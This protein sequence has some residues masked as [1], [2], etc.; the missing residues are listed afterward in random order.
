MLM[1]S[2]MAWK[3]MSRYK[4]RTVITAFAI[5]VG[6]AISIAVQA[7]LVGLD[8]DSF[9]NL[10]WYETASAKVYAPGYFKER[11]QYPIENLIPASERLSLERTLDAQGVL[12][13][14]RYQSMAEIFFLEDT[15]PTTGSL[16]GIVYGVDPIRDAEVYKIASSVDEG[17]WLAPGE[18]GVV[19]G[20]WLAY[21]MQAEVGYYVTIQCKG[22]GGFVQT[23]DVPVVGIVQTDNPVVNTTAMYMD[24]DYLDEMLEL[25]GDVSD[26]SL[27]L[28]SLSAL[29][30]AK[31]VGR[32][33]PRLQKNLSGLEV[34]GWEQ[35]AEDEVSMSRTKSTASNLLLIFLFIIAA[36]GISNTMLMAVME[37]KDEI[38][39]L[40]TL[41]YSRKHIEFL[42]V[43]EGVFIG[44]LGSVVGLVAGIGLTYPLV[45]HGLDF[46]SLF[47]GVNIGYRISGIMRG[48]WDVKSCLVTAAGALVVSAISAWFPVRK[49]ART[50]IAVIFRQI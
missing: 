30:G 37:R 46:T 21:D 48:A 35:V 19:L 20:S 2:R 24:L 1:L 34:Y 32:L 5:A 41:G 11:R 16:T 28:P 27:S 9:K 15:F 43:S 26:Y 36:V 44:L 42:F 38:G 39:M 4:K 25:E 45:V 8:Q 22:K 23:M 49:I 3:N 50:E 17:D 18:E 14:P 29:H 7:L 33:L 13:A 12:Y 10:I 6:V 31:Q 47:E 40:K